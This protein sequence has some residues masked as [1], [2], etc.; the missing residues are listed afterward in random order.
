MERTQVAAIACKKLE[1][2][3]AAWQTATEGVEEASVGSLSESNGQKLSR[4]LRQMSFRTL[5][6]D[7]TG[8]IVDGI[9]RGKCRLCDVRAC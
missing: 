8:M 2:R 4:Q 5:C 6:D 9:E 3:G 7:I 1:R